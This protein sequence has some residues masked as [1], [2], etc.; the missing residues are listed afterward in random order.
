[1]GRDAHLPLDAATPSSPDDPAADAQS[2]RDRSLEHDAENR[3]GALQAAG[4]VSPPDGDVFTP[5]LLQRLF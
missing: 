2:Q 5:P 4:A 1:M 3:V